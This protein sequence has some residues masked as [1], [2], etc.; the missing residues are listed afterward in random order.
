MEL[1]GRPP[2]GNKCSSNE[3]Q[4]LGRTNARETAS[5][6]QPTGP[7]ASQT[8]SSTISVI[9]QSGMSQ[10]LGLISVDGKNPCILDSGA[11][12]HLIGFLEHFVSYTPCAGNDKIWT[13]D[14]SLTP[15]AGKGQI[16]LFNGFSLQ[17][18]LHVPKLCPL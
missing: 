2:R 4:N 3:Q 16:V 6:S 17:N 7:T 12:D 5:T 9:A 14:G 11:T 18:V 8:S 15:I 13:V 1:H 10:P